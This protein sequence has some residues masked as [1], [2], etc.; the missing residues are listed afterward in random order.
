MLPFP[1][2]LSQNT[3][4]TGTYKTPTDETQN[5]DKAAWMKER[6]MCSKFRCQVLIVNI[7]WED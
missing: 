2:S 4:K 3:G 7:K 6:C 5:W 1:F